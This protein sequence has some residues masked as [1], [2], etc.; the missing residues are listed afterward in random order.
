[1]ADFDERLGLLDCL[2]LSIG[3]M[4]GSA[5]FIF[6]G[7]TGRLVGPGAI[8]A[9]VVA[10][11]LMFTIALCYTELALAFPET[12]SIAVFPAETLGP[13]P[14]VRAFASYLEG[15]GYA[16]G[17]VFG[18]TISALAIAD[19]LA[20]FLPGTGGYVVPIAL[21][22]IG[23]AALVNLLGVGVTTRTNLLLSAFL[24]SVLLTFA[25]A[26]FAHIQPSNYRPLFKGDTLHFFAAVQIALTAYGAWTAIPAAIEEVENPEHTVPRA[27]LLSLAVTTVLYATIVTAVHGVVSPAQFVAGSATVTAPLGVAADVLGSSWLRYVLAIAAVT[28]IFT[29]VLVGVMSAGRVLFA[30]GQRNTLPPIFAA[31]GDRFRV[32]WVGI[33]TVTVAAGALAAVPHVFDELLV[34]AAVVGTGLPYAINLLS[35]VGLRYYRTDVEPSFRAPGGYAL[36]GA[37]FVVLAIA[38]LGLGATEVRWSLGALVLLGGYFLARVALADN[39]VTAEVNS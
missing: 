30:L 20:V 36:P 11:V 27:I 4:V 22:A 23:L 12:G 32:P 1:M 9:W 28:A 5:I 17:W 13:S 38:M 18:I 7:T 21:L 8:L 2:L 29:T 26:G 3:G 34:I 25:A 33:V 16:I 19:Y 39:V 37:A 6:P 10:G 35:F 31:K 24:L 15:V 14:S